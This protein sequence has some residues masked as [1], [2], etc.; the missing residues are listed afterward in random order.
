VDFRRVDGFCLGE[1]RQNGE[2]AERG[3]VRSEGRLDSR[4]SQEIE[5]LAAFRAAG[6]QCDKDQQLVASA[7]GM[8]N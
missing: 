5:V 2:L 3:R 4:P 7:A 6:F 8:S 1:C